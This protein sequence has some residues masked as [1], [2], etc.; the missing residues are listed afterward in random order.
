[1]PADFPEAVEVSGLAQLMVETDNRWERVKLARA[2]GWK[3]PH[4][5]PDIDPPHEALQVVE[6]YREATRLPR[7]KDRP[8]DFRRRLDEAREAAERLEATLRPGQGKDV[9]G[10]AAER[11]FRAA[12]DAC[13]NCHVVYRDVPRRR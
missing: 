1:L 9:D 3:M 10:E 7:T 8:D 6:Q 12:G 13:T 2:A 4:D 11:A 5:H